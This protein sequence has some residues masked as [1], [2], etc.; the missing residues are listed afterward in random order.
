M[1]RFEVI[2]PRDWGLHAPE[3]DGEKSRVL[4]MMGESYQSVESR[5]RHAVLDFLDRLYD[6]EEKGLRHYYRADNQFLS[7]LDAGNFMMAMNYLV[8]YDMNGDE[9]LLAKAENC[10]KWAYDHATETHPMFTWQGGVRDGFKPNELYT[11]YTG[12]ACLTAA[13]LYRRTE[14]DDYLFYIQQFHNFFKQARK[15]GFKHKYDTNTYTW[16]NK[17]FVW[18]A[19]GSIINSYLEIYELTDQEKYKQ[20]ALLWGENAL[21]LKEGQ[22]FYLIDGTF[23][24]SDLA[25][26][27]LRALV[28]LYEISEDE[29]Y[30]NAAKDYADWLID[31]QRDDGAW[32]IGIDKDDEIVAPNVGPGDTPNIALAMMRLHMH[33]HD[34]RLFGAMKK[35][36]RYSLRMQAVE[37]GRYPLH[38]DDPHV[39]WGFWS[40]EPLMDYSLSG[41]QSVH[42]I[43]GMLFFAQ[44]LATITEA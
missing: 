22:G 44:Y 21:T 13:A 3:T 20:E 41:D 16:R 35:A 31:H 40:W 2:H 14:K 26:Q 30:L 28:Y 29:R 12:D 10:F 42:H 8:V 24:N 19:F 18:R 15:A 34:E 5:V 9:V 32:V 7:E 33:T 11:K 25:A 6:E 1:K 43:R 27:E 17:G 23:W 39:K 4:D 37:S 36:I 38:L